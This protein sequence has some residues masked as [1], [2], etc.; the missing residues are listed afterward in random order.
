MLSLEANLR[1]DL[2]KKTKKLRKKG[3]IPGV[4]YGPGINNALLEIE[5]KKFEKIYKQTGESELI[6]LKVQGSNS[7]VPAKTKKEKKDE[8]LV[9]IKDITLDPITSKPIHIDFFQ[10]NLKEEI[11]VEV[12][13]VLKGEAPAVKALGGT[14]IKVLSFIKIKALPQKL[15]HQIEVD[16]STLQNFDDFISVKNL[17][18]IEGVKILNDQD[19]IIAQ[20]VRP[21]KVE[22]E[23]AKPTEEKIEEVTEVKKEKKEEE[24]SLEGETTEIKKDEKVEKTEKVEK[25]GK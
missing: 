20:V 9:L 25:K 23:L 21:E 19:E 22:E 3:I 6:N 5:L 13:I 4:L 17:S 7:P 16:V 15:I 2:G 24:E 8:F 18:K 1:Q 14:L 12:P 11:E 10:P